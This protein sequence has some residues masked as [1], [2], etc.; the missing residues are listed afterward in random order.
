MI[1]S[2]LTVL[3]GNVAAQLIGIAVLPILS[4]HFSPTA[5]GNFYAF[6]AIIGFLLVLVTLRYEI[7]IL[8]MKDDR[9]L[10]AILAMCGLALLGTTG[11]CAIFLGVTDALGYPAVVA[12]LQFPLW[13]IP[14]AMAFGGA[15]Q[16]LGY[17][18][19]KQHRFGQSSNSKIVQSMANAG[20]CVGLALTMPSTSG[21]ILGDIAGKLVLT[22]WLARLAMK[23][24]RSAFSASWRDIADAAYRFRDLSLL[25]LPTT[26]INIGGLSIT[27]MLVYS[28][29]G[30][31]VAGQFGM[32]ER[33]AGLPVAMIVA[34]VSQVHMA[35]LASDLQHGGDSARRNFKRISLYLA[36]LAIGPAV[37][38]AIFA[39]TIFHYVLGP[40][41][42]EAARI[43]QIMAPSY[44]LGLVTGGV[45]MTLTV[46][47]RQTIQLLWA[48]ARLVAMACLWLFAPQAGWGIESVVIVYSAILCL[49]S[50]LM[51]VLSYQALPKEPAK[52][53]EATS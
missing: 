3:K 52:L 2:I 28:Q 35:Y 11:L 13:L 23:E 39:Q 32:A 53:A 14:V 43:A 34:A 45:N 48:G 7:A 49:F 22:L 40:G 10:S 50:V 6:Q 17:I 47:G 36:L 15:A 31:A 27:P 42:E 8:R 41:W 30:S 51:A 46:V 24:I 19:V 18:L 12:D 33:T 25:S 16:L 44:F 37:G 38:G 21:V 20:T 4:R 29:F 9:E 26:L 5:F 1:R